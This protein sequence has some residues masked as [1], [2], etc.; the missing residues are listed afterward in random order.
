MKLTG[1][2]KFFLGI[3]FGTLTIIGLAVIL[4]TRPTKPLPKEL[5]IPST[6]PTK[7]NKDAQ[8]WL[9]EFSDF[10]CPACK[11]FSL[12]V[13]DLAKKYPD[14][15][16]VA[17]RHFPLDQHIYSTIT[18]RA[19]QLAHDKSKFWDLSAT[20]FENQEKIATATSQKEAREIIIQLA[21]TLFPVSDGYATDLVGNKGDDT[22][23]KD[24]LYG[25]AIG[26]NATPTFFLNGVK[27]EARTPD[28]LKKKVEEAIKNHEI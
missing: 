12:A 8:V 3:I 9:V 13:D 4:L 10:Q 27:L 7:G 16:L 19:A 26:I 23:Q 14:T 15:L 20:L 11:V 1:E 21:T 28:E 22:V 17:Y 25:N 6:A 24:R 2:S 18:A 5:L